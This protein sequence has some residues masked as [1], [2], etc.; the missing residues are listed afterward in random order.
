MKKLIYK[1]N[2]S[3]KK[4]QNLKIVKEIKYLVLRT[5]KIILYLLNIPKN[6]YTLSTNKS[7]IFFVLKIIISNIK[8]AIKKHQWVDT[9]DLKIIAIFIFYK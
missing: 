8:K 2:G 9:C 7:K 3:K 4:I 1:Y 6:E 5:L